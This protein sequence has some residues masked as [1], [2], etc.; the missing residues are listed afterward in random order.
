[1]PQSVLADIQT[2][3]STSR[4]LPLYHEGGRPEFVVDLKLLFCVSLDRGIVVVH[5]WF[6]DCIDNW[7]YCSFLF[8]QRIFIIFMLFSQN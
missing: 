8:L 3:S 7:N 1:M 2:T 5:L 4:A 6:H